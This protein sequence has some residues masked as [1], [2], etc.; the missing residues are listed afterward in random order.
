MCQMWFALAGDDRTHPSGGGDRLRKD[1]F[2][3]QHPSH[4]GRRQVQPSPAEHFSDLDLAEL[5]T[6]HLQPPDDVAD[7]V[8]KLVHRLRRLQESARSESRRW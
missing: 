1:R 7:Q 8:G 6:E 5:G 3:L 4:R 2:L